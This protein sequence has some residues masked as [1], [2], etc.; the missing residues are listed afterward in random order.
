MKHT[1]AS[2][3][4]AVLRSARDRIAADREAV[5]LADFTSYLQAGDSNDCAD[6]VREYDDL[7]ARIDAALAKLARS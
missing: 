3:L 6:K 4:T 2:D 1:P 7:L 5:F